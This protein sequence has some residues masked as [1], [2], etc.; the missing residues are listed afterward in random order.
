M[1]TQAEAMRFEHLKCHQTPGQSSEY[2]PSAGNRP[3]G[4]YLSG[5]FDEAQGSQLQGGTRK[6]PEQVP[7][8]FI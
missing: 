3:W 1:V 6:K 2:A 7:A 4:S 8:F 5:L